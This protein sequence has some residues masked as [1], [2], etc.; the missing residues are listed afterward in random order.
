MKN[1]TV[2]PAK[3]ED[4][5]MYFDWLKAASE[6]NL[7]DPAA[8]SY[9]TCNTVVIEKDG[10]P[11][12]MNSFH[13][14]LMMEALAPKP[15]LPPM[16]EARALKTLFDSVK[17]VAE[18]SGVKEIWFGCSDERVIRFATRHGI[19]QVKFPMLRMKL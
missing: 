17:K 19:E 1:I 13:L 3:P 6:I 18:A 2:R 16:D 9:P 7:V 8:Y 4:A 12:L 5:Q 14:T 10:D 15:G 11:V